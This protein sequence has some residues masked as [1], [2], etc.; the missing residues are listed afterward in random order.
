MKR[1]LLLL[2][3]VGFFA[4]G[5]KTDTTTVIASGE[6]GV[7][8]NISLEQSRVVLG[9]K[10]GD[11]Y[12]V[13]WSEG[14][15]IAVNG[16]LSDEAVIDAQNR[17]EATFKFSGVESLSYPLSITYPYCAAATTEQACVEFLAE[18]SYAEGSFEAGV[19]PMCGFCAKE[20]DNITLS[21][22]SAILHFPIVAKTEGVVLD[23][24]EVVSKSKIA[25]VFEVNCQNA[26][27]SATEN[28]GN[29]KLH[30]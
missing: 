28:C 22:L 9:E 3:L 10:V 23:R 19:A 8:L 12:P 25:G 6:K 7:T 24:V 27:V 5:C 1:Y 17:A 15:K 21:H 16:A 26:T 14:D 11:T 20:G 4:V 29:R 13:Y 30:L 2:A 18:Q